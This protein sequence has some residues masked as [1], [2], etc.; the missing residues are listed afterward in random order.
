ML[1]LSDDSGLFITRRWGLLCLHPD[2]WCIPSAWT[3]I[4]CH[5]SDAVTAFQTS[6]SGSLLYFQHSAALY[7]N[8]YWCRYRLISGFVL[9]WPACMQKPTSSLLW[10]HLCCWAESFLSDSYFVANSQ[11][12]QL[13]Q[14]AKILIDT[15][16]AVR[17]GKIDGSN[18][19]VS[20]SQPSKWTCSG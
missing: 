5:L 14:W 10:S 1:G 8:V 16:L 15:N 12:F 17:K 6:C 9:V 19:G 2:Q 4:L 13:H 7:N 20:S 11:Q 18:K 3:V